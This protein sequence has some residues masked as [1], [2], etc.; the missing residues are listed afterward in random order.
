MALRTSQDNVGSQYK[1]QGYDE[2]IV[3]DEGLKLEMSRTMTMKRVDTVR[4]CLRM[5]VKL[6]KRH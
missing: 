1:T 5:A 6:A 2:V 3:A 4:L